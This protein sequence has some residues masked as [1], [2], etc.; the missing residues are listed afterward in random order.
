MIIASKIKKL[1]IEKIKLVIIVRPEAKW[2][3][4]Y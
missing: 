2:S 1:R 4:Y 3:N